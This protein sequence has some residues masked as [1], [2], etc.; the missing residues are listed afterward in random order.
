MV[1]D[2]MSKS[3]EE[4]NIYTILE[5]DQESLHVL[6]F[7][8]ANRKRS[9]PLTSFSPSLSYGYPFQSLPCLTFLIND[10]WQWMKPEVRNNG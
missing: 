10:E 8:C 4:I 7:F 3:A 5:D 6:C 2:S 9:L 1:L